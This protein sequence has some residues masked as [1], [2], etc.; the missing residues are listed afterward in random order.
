MRGILAILTVGL[1]LLVI[2]IAP[3]LDRP[4]QRVI[5][6]NLQPPVA[7]SV[8]VPPRRR[9]CQRELVPDGTG[10]I[11]LRA[12]TYGAPGPPLRVVISGS[13]TSSITGRLRRGWLEGDVT[14]PIP[15]VR[16][17]RREAR[18]CVTNNGS[19]RLALAGTNVAAA[20]SARVGGRRS[21]GRMSL[22]YLEP[23][24]TTV[25][26]TAPELVRRVS[27]VRDALP[28]SATLPLAVLLALGV[29]GGAGM[30]L[31][32]EARA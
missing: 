32:R 9:A 31:A 29:V 4:K 15:E 1:A 22:V 8:I 28:G 18:L 12:G 30:L 27:V 2:G 20:S 7:F 26:A 6:A 17:D 21:G 10:A 23:S 16:G 5:R 19:R 25:I 24:Q 3:A 14:V 13:A 11:W